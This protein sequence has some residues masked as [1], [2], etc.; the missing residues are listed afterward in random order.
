[1]RPTPCISVKITGCRAGGLVEQDLAFPVRGRRAAALF[2]PDIDATHYRLARSRVERLTGAAQLFSL[3]S[4]QYLLPHK[5]KPETMRAVLII[6]AENAEK[7]RCARGI[8]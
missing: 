4:L 1:R 8:L 5:A 6:P 2:L 3:H 7:I